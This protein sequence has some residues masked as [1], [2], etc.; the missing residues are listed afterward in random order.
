MKSKN[1]ILIILLSVIII[2]LLIYGY[3]KAVPGISDQA[4]NRPQIEITPSFF[5]FGEIQYG[6]VAKHTFKIKNLGNEVLEI[7]KVATSCACTSAEASQEKINPGEEADLFITYNTGAMSG[8]HAK[9][10][11]ERIIYI[12]SNDPVNP[13]TEIIIK[14]Y[15][16]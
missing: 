13:Q 9:G 2:G 14:A 6:D 15:V 11:Q 8:P 5:D 7:I 3:F 10:A 4:E 12:K 16:K 1:I